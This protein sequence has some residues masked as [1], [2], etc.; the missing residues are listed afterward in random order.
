MKLPCGGRED[1]GGCLEVERRNQG[2]VSRRTE[3]ENVLS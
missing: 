3:R 2:D 1:Q